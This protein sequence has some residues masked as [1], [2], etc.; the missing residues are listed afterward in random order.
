M[1][2][3]PVPLEVAELLYADPV[4]R[5]DI[6]AAGHA[7]APPPSDWT[8]AIDGDEFVTTYHIDSEVGLRVFVDT[9]K[10]HNLVPQLVTQ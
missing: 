3:G 7:G 1:V 8:T 4:G 2:N 9:L 6:R 10:L 5:T